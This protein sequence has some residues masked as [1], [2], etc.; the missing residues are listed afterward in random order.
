MQGSD[1]TPCICACTVWKQGKQA[2]AG[3]N[4]LNTCCTGCLAEVAGSLV[5]LGIEVFDPGLI[6]S[7]VLSKSQPVILLL[8]GCSGPLL[9]LLRI[10]V[11]DILV[12]MKA[13]VVASHTL[14]Q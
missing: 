5:Q 14:L 4:S 9:Q 12:L 2:E 10:P 6:L 1:L 13:V 11:H 8:K 3:R 7:L